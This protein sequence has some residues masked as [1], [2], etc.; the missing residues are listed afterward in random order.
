MGEQDIIE[1]RFAMGIE[2]ENEIPTYCAQ[3]AQLANLVGVYALEVKSGKYRKEKDE[4]GQ[5][6]NIVEFRAFGKND[7]CKAFLRMAMQPCDNREDASSHIEGHFDDDEF[8]YQSKTFDDKIEDS[9]NET[10]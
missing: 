5:E 1:V 7:A 4:H 6:F 8:T 3:L 10:P 2:N 9:L